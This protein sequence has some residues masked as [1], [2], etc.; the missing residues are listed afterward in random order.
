MQKKT[1][2][3]IKK[4]LLAGLSVFLILTTVLAVHIYQVTRPGTELVNANLEM[5]RIDFHSPI[6]S[7]SAHRVKSLT[8]SIEGVKHVYFNIPDGIMVYGFS[9]DITNGQEVFEK[10]M[11]QSRLKGERYEVSEEQLASSCPVINKSSLTYKIGNAFERL[12]VS[13]N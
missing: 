6:D 1:V 7:T 10:I 8:R 3:I 5:A 13:F 2:I 4:I 11:A 9:S 12:F